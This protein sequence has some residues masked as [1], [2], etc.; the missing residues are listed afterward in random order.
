MRRIAIVLLLLSAT[1]APAGV[2]DYWRLD[3]TSQSLSC[4]ALVLGFGF[5]AVNIALAVRSRRK[6]RHPPGDN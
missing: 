4:C 5:V 1:A 6:A 2:E 3:V